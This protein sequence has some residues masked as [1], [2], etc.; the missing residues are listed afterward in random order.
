MSK[1]KTICHASAASGN[2]KVCV[3]VRPFVEREHGER[4]CVQMPSESQVTLDDCLEHMSSLRV[5]DY[6][7]AYWSCDDSHPSCATQ[8][9]LMDELGEAILDNAMDGFNNCLFAYGQTGSGKTHSVLGADD[10]PE[11]RGLLPRI[12]LELFRRIETMRGAK[13]A[14]L[15]FQC[16]VSYLEIYNAAEQS[17]SVICLY[18]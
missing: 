11:N 13:D 16:Q 9:T 10:Q 18:L 4:C 2:I 15:Q 3:R 17:K 8:Q 1:R 6:D 14:K 12:L 5:F 7:R